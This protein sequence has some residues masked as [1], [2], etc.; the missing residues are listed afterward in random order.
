MALLPS[1]AGL[2][3]TFNVG[4]L[5]LTRRGA[6]TR[7]EYGEW[8][9]ASGT[10][11]ILNPVAAHNLSG[12]DRANLPEAI[13]EREAIEVY[14][15]VRVYSGNDGQAADTLVY[16]GRTYV[17]IQTMDYDLQGDV[18]ISIWTLEDEVQP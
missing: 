8:V 3:N 18:Y 9:E 13:R 7:N 16:R 4:P 15:R 1:V 6:P 10:S 14:T 11:V 12:R 5:T 2:L 17:C